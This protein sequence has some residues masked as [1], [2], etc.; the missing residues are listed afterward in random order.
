M[1]ETSYELGDIVRWKHSA[2]ETSHDYGMVIKLPEVVLAGVYTFTNQL[3]EMMD[4]EDDT[5]KLSE[6]LVA[7][8]VYSFGDQKVVTLYKTPED[9]PLFI[10]KVTFSEKSS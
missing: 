8:T 10:E 5:F 1:H 6:P 3:V 9:V 4:I 2:G 7:L